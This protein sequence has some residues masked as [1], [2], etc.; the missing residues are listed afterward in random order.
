MSKGAN[1]FSQHCVVNSTHNVYSQP[2]ASIIQP[3]PC[4]VLESPHSVRRVL[5]HMQTVRQRG[6]L[7]LG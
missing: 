4:A 1:S 6:D 7:A 5:F 2:P 3:N